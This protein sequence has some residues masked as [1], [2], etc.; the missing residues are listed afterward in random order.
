MPDQQEPGVEIRLGISETDRICAAE[1]FDAAFG[2]KLRVMI[3]DGGKR[4]GVIAEALDLD[5]AFAAY[6]PA[7]LTGLCGF[8]HGGR[9]FTGQLGA[10]LLFR[11]LGVL[12]GLRACLIG[13]LLRRQPKAAE[14]LLDGIA[15]AAN[16]RSLGIGARLLTTAI[17][18]AKGNG[19]SRLRLDVVDSNTR[20]RALYERQGFVPESTR[21][22]A[23]WTR[24][25]GFSSVTGMC[26]DLVR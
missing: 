23:K 20:A 7:G 11:H 18:F 2:Q 16:A 14:C 10:A 17:S 22:T 21:D 26:L 8:H 9:S 1:L 4:C 13:S 6:G 12:G 19:Y 5:R 25:L 24:A 3:P 15:V